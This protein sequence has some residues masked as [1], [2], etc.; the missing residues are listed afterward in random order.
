MKNANIEVAGTTLLQEN[1]YLP[2]RCS[3]MF[4]F[5]IAAALLIAWSGVNL[6]GQVFAQPPPGSTEA[7]MTDLK[8]AFF[9][10][11]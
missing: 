4:Y 2:G 5:G 8:K 1:R 11:A 6:E 10:S 3:A 7:G 9:L